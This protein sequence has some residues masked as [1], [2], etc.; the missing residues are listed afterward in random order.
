MDM[1]TRLAKLEKAE[2]ERLCG[3]MSAAEAMLKTLVSACF[4]QAQLGVLDILVL[5]AD[6]EAR[7]LPGDALQGLYL[8]RR[9]QA[10]L[11]EV[12]W[13]LEAHQWSIARLRELPAEGKKN[14]A[15]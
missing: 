14:E 10:S 8:K 3:E 4:S 7:E 11:E 9:Q 2:H 6:T 1:K 15:T 13:A 12:R 5:S